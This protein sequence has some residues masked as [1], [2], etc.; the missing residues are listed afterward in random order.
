MGRSRAHSIALDEA[1]PGNLVSRR[2]YL[3]NQCICCHTDYIY[4]KRSSLRIWGMCPLKKRWKAGSY[5]KTGELLSQQ[6]PFRQHISNSK[7]RIS[8]PYNLCHPQMRGVMKGGVNDYHF[9]REFGTLVVLA[10]HRLH[11]L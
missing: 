5:T 8:T 9:Q 10:M 11:N 6:K 3:A 4:R 7:F 1:H 2:P